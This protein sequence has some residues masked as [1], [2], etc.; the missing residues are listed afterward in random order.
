METPQMQI[1]LL[2]IKKPATNIFTC[3]TNRIYRRENN[4]NGT[5]YNYRYQVIIIGREM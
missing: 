5:Y 4:V 2:D 3:Q 1:Q